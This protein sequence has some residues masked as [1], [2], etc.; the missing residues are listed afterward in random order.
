MCE[1]NIRQEFST[2]RDEI[3]QLNSQ[4]FALVGGSLTINFTIIGFGISKSGTNDI[5]PMLP[6]IGILLLVAS[7]ILIAHKI[8]MAHRLAY[9]I[10][11]YIAPNLKGIKWSDVYFAYRK[12]SDSGYNWFVRYI[13]ERFVHTHGVLPKN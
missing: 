10:K 4:A 13:A 3:L 5:N 7:N 6:F 9:F 11:I 12:R 8:R 1:S 2:I